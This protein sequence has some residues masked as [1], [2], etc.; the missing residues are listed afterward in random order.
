M[1]REPESRTASSGPAISVDG[2][3]IPFNRPE[4]AGRELEYIADAVRRGHL[5]GD[6]EYTRRCHRALSELLGGAHVLLTTS[7]TH[8]LELAALV[9]DVKLGD[10][11]I[12]PSF[13]FTS[14]ANAFLLRGATPVFA[15]IRPDTLNLDEAAVERRI[16]PRTRAIVPVHYAG[17]G[18]EMEELL[19]IAEAA[20]T[21][22]VEDNAHGLFGAY[23]RQPLGTF[24]RLAT[25]SFHETKNVICGEGGA[26]VIN[27]L[28]LLDRAEVLREKGTN[29]SRFFRGEVDRYTW[30]E[31]GSS[32]LPAEVI[33]AFL[34]AQLEARAALQRARAVVWQRYQKELTPWAD[35]RGAALPCV[36]PH[37]EHPS[38]LFYLLMA[39]AEQRD[40]LIGHLGER[41]V[42]A[43]FHYLPLHLSPVGRRF[44]GRRGDCP[45]A[46]SVSERL[47]RLPCFPGLREEEQARVVDAVRSF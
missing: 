43:V 29:R 13:T 38:H 20:G 1:A 2:E 4:L 18:C 14:T 37:C 9:L 25:L 47:V 23:R 19:A 35:G 32:Y 41:G 31:V 36:P 24:G 28:S 3:R 8:A 42:Q 7:C 22:I 30:E 44:G 39:T 15:D 46:E 11:V 17:V 33:A 34:F 21:A 27:D 16:T 10:E 5:S 40:A 6:G 12:L 26:L 45:V